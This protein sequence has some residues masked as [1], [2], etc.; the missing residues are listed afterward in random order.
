MIA[1]IYGISTKRIQYFVSAPVIDTSEYITTDI[2]AVLVDEPPELERGPY[3]NS[4]GEVAYPPSAPFP[5]YEFNYVTETWFNPRALDQA[6]LLI[7]AAFTAT[8]DTYLYSPLDTPYGRFKCD[9]RG[10]L[11]IMGAVQA[12]DK[13]VQRALPAS[14]PTSASVTFVLLDNS[15]VTLNNT[16]IGNVGLLLAARISAIYDY[17]SDLT[18]A[19]DAC[20][21]EAELAALTWD[22]P[23]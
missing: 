23:V 8:R 14:E 10:Q 4:S 5:Y 7:G 2:G 15:K 1:C 16:E 6:K 22:P 17:F 13:I 12:S 20:T 9:L 18:V 19:I 3:V 21:T 11:N